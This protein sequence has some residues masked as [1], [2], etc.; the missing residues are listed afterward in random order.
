[1]TKRSVAILATL[2][3]IVFAAVFYSKGRQSRVPV[4]PHTS[5]HAHSK[6]PVVKNEIAHASVRSNAM[7]TA[8]L[9]YSDREYTFLRQHYKSPNPQAY[10]ALSGSQLKQLRSVMNHG[11]VAERQL[12]PVVNEVLY[13]KTSAI[14]NRLD[15]GMN[16]N[17][18]VFMGY[19]YASNVSLLDIAIR[20]GQRNIIKILL[21]HGASVNPPEMVAQNGTPYKFEGPL[22]LAA[23]YG[24]DDVVKELLQRD[25]NVNQLHGLESDNN[26][27]LAQAMYSGNI[28]TVYLLLTHGADVHS[29]LGPGGTVPDF[30]VKY[31]PGPRKT[32][33]RN[34]LVKYGAQMPAK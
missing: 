25:A 15:T 4:Q 10:G 28:S 34:L 23:E 2:T 33:L 21:A 3:A 32:A 19:P 17:A 27:A 13:G 12:L 18:T 1:M 24:E 29:V 7:P 20:A 8:R 16:P 31:S 6:S 11:V 30:L 5:R 9:G 26:S 22:A 14:E